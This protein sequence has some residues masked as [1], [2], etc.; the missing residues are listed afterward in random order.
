MEI[1]LIAIGVL[2]GFSIFSIFVST[3]Y[4]RYKKNNVIDLDLGF[5]KIRM[6]KLNDVYFI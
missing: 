6:D 2:C 4:L 1:I 5:C 3:C